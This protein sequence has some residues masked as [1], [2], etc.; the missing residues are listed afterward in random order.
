MV[1]VTTNN[2]RGSDDHSI[3]DEE[4]GRGMDGADAAAAREQQT[5]I[6]KNEDNK[7]EA[8]TLDVTDSTRLSFWESQRSRLLGLQL[9]Y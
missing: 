7:D 4:G 5:N 8:P 2:E 6:A 9:E 3:P 1:Y